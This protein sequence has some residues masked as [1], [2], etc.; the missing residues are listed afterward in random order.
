MRPFQFLNGQRRAGHL[1]QR[2]RAFLHPGA[3]GGGEDHHR[4]IAGNGRLGGGDE[5]FAG[6]HAERSAHKGE[7][8]N[9]DDTINALHLA[10]ADGHDIAFPGG[11]AGSLQAVLVGLAVGEV[12]RV[13]DHVRRRQAFELAV[14]KSEFHARLGTDTHMAAGRCHPQGGLKVRAIDHVAGIGVFHPQVFRCF[15][16]AA[17]E[18]GDAGGDLGQPATALAAFGGLGGGGQF[19]AL[20]R[21]I[22]HSHTSIYS[23]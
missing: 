23:G 15:A 22:S 1:H 11:G 19:R 20:V 5:A 10:V 3:T 2:Q 12:Q 9:E 13:F 14:I 7:I 17:D 16:L 8:L 4:H 6:G 21:L 18:I